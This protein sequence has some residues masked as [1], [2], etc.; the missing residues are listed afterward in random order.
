MS[1]YDSW[2]E[3]GAHDF[4]SEEIWLDERVCELMKEECNPNA[5]HNLTEAIGED[6]LTKHKEQ[7]EEALQT[8][9]FE[10]LG[11]LI[12]S[13]VYDYWENQANNWA[14]NEWQQGLGD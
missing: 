2:L 3:S 5:F 11:R 4:E 9:N 6:C 10:V 1:R 14:A 8:R 7:I 13:D 12:W